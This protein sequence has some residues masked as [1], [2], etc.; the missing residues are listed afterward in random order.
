MQID[1]NKKYNP[2]EFEDVI[3]NM[4]LS[5]NCFKANVKTSKM[6]Y[7]IAMPPPNV[8]GK[9]HMGHALD[10]T[11]QDIIIRFKKMQGFETLWVPGV[12]HAAIAT[13]A[14]LVEQLRVEGLT[15]EEVGKE[16]FLKRAFKWKD[17]YE[18]NIVNQLRKLGVSCDW[19]RKRFTMDEGC[20][21]AVL[22]YFIRLYK[23]G[24][25][26]RG[27]R[28]INWCY[29]CKTSISDIEVDFKEK[30]GCFYYIKYK[31]EG[32]QDFL[33][34]ATTRPETLFGDVA[35]AVH[36]E[37][38]RYRS[39]IGKFLVVPILNRKIPIIA[40]S[41]VDRDFGSGVVKITPGHDFNDFEV[42][43]RHNLKPIKLFDE[44]G[45]LNEFCGKFKG[46]PRA[47]A[48]KEV[49]N[50]LENV[51]LLIKSVPVKHNVGHCY[52][53]GAVVEPFL[54]LQWFV[55]MEA[56]KEP[57]LEAA[58]AGQVEFVPKRFE[59]I[60]FNWMENVKDWCI[61]RQ[62]WWGHGIPAYYCSNCGHIN[63]AKSMPSCCEK[64]S[65]KELTKDEDTLDTWF[66][67]ALWP[68]AILGW[69]NEN[70]EYYKKFYPT[71][72][73]VT[74]YDI[75][76]FWVSRMIFSGLYNTKNVPFK[77]VFIHGLVRD[78]Q[79]RKMSKS[80]GNGVDPLD[81]IKRYGA[82][83]LR[84]T[85]ASGVNAGNDMR[86][87]EKKVLAS[88]NFANKL[89]N[90][91][92]FI[93]MQVNEFDE[94][95]SP[96]FS[97]ILLLNKEKLYIEDR[98]ILYKLNELIKEVSRNIECFDIS[99]AADKLYDFIWNVFCDWYIELFK[100]KK[101][102]N[103]IAKNYLRGA[104]EDRYFNAENGCF[105]SEY[106]KMRAQQSFNII[107][108]ALDVVL[109]ILH[110]FMPFITQE[111][112]F[113][114]YGSNRFILNYG[115]PAPNDEFNF[116]AEYRLFEGVIKIVKAVRNFRAQNNIQNKLNLNI[117]LTSD[118]FNSGFINSCRHFIE[119]L[120]GCHILGSSLDGDVSG[121]K[122]VITDVAVIDV[123]LDN[124]VN[125][126]EE[127]KK[128]QNQKQYLL[129]EI[130]IFKQKL[131]NTN[132][133]NKAPKAVVEA[134]VRKLE[135]KEAELKTVEA[136][137]KSLL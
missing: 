12:D 66:S 49:A 97:K 77:K 128:L 31:L 26:Y 9:L 126:D 62:L 132:F 78:E 38:E 82:D 79:G 37:D 67:A 13:E 42:G 20:R 74:G 89:Y 34:V 33:Q 21:E 60:Y 32:S 40:D 39:Y 94:N 23:D 68:F 131:S 124:V 6:P 3:Y 15:K 125:K 24:L 73:L 57:A 110:P 104:D 123:V 111:I 127:I 108:Y 103:F 4:W 10:E 2:S 121:C 43:L 29:T 7:T 52:R 76:F 116:E 18:G 119:K 53:C 88:R 75:I 99:V 92:R 41:Y 28:L 136:S 112:Y 27:E 8:T 64:C 16:E 81:I 45:N 114:L 130:K 101:V 133:K 17:E 118:V 69:P 107:F 54:S 120:G 48:R 5:N 115:W 36:P 83:A 22:E 98:W 117:Y 50:E 85:L 102:N 72:T 71:T 109:K 19:S 105:N 106:V 1:F 91:A 80:L 137:L 86:Y 25:I 58:K 63:V 65:C 135:S 30:D 100:I 90:A 95:F 14:K 44:D 70:N 59:K 56:L 87:S 134:A 61:S 96:D 55:K 84:F 113:K 35:V 93:F 51:G 122:R 47:K 46:M 11:L 129:G